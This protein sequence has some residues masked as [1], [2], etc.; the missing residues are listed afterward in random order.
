[1]TDSTKRCKNCGSSDLAKNRRIC[2]KC[3]AQRSKEHYHTKGKAMRNVPN[4]NCKACRKKFKSWRK[5]QVLCKQCRRESLS[6]GYLDKQYL[7]TKDARLQHRVLVEQL[8]GRKLNRN[9][10]VH[11]VD[12]NP[13]NNSLDNLWVMSQ[14][15]HCKLHVLL[16]RERVIYEKSLDKHSVNCWNVLRAKHTTAWLETTSANVIKMD[17]LDNQQPST[18][19]GKGSETKHGAS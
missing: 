7:Y 18:L 16:R 10:I 19:T 17:R 13:Q 6:T 11:H 12:E 1:M 14:S 8:L 2:K 5:E 15:D 3:N 9:E 4:T